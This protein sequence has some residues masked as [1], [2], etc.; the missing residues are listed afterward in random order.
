M[1]LI[2]HI[3]RLETGS[4]PACRYGGARQ[5]T[6]AGIFPKLTRAPRLNQLKMGIRNVIDGQDSRCDIDHSASEADWS[7]QR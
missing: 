5:P 2:G 7:E 6:E 1:K 3:H 4:T